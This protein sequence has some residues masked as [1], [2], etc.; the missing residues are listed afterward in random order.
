MP[1]LRRCLTETPTG[2][3]SVRIAPLSTPTSAFL[4]SGVRYIVNSPLVAYQETYSIFFKKSSAPDL[5]FSSALQPTPALYRVRVGCGA[6]SPSLATKTNHNPVNPPHLRTFS[7][8]CL[9]PIYRDGPNPLYR[10]EKPKHQSLAH[11]QR[12]GS[13]AY[14]SQGH[15]GGQ[16]KAKAASYFIRGTRSH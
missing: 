12:V 7:T 11:G 10:K 2:S 4:D 9:P 6:H 8:Q 15:G 16:T 14:P 3:L 13:S 1:S 5:S